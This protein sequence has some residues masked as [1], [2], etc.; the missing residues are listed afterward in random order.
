MSIQKCLIM[1]HE[2]QNLLFHV[3]NDL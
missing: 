1:I 3:L 2:G